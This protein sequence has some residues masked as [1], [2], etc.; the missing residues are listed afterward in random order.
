M[1]SKMIR[2]GHRAEQTHNE[3]GCC[4]TTR[5]TGHRSSHAQGLKQQQATVSKNVQHVL[6]PT[7]EL[8][9]VG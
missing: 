7:L 9:Q 2:R 6:P 1:A 8:L 3:C 4:E 5:V